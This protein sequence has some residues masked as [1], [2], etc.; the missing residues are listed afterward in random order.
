MKSFILLVTFVS[1]VTGAEG[2]LPKLTNWFW[3]QLNDVSAAELADSMAPEFGALEGLA[4]FR[5]SKTD[6][7]R[8]W[9]LSRLRAESLPDLR[10]GLVNR[11]EFNIETLKQAIDMM[12]EGFQVGAGVVGMVS[13]D[14]FQGFEVRNGDASIVIGMGVLEFDGI[15]Y[16]HHFTLLGYVV[17]AP[18]EVRVMQF[19]RP[20]SR[21]RLETLLNLL[22]GGDHRVL[23]RAVV[24]RERAVGRLDAWDMCSALS[25]GYDQNY[26][27]LADR[28]R[29]AVGTDGAIR[30]LDKAILGEVERELLR[31]DGNLSLEYFDTI[32]LME[33]GTASR[34]GGRL[35]QFAGLSPLVAV[36]VPCT[37]ILAAK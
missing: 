5:Y 18:D 25:G 12:E 26:R 16:M 32:E 3:S 6:R 33:G 28:L 11:L 1:T 23:A 10:L 13:V 17:E 36:S 4:E 30:V 34:Q 31:L 22:Y 20:F 21:G 7:A 2:D 37:T 27:S 15:S 24:R 9:H 35:A 8:K 19:F 14:D 29:E